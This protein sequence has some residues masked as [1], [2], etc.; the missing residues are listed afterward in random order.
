[1]SI[2]ENY[3]RNINPPSAQTFRDF[4]EAQTLDTVRLLYHALGY[5]DV[6]IEPT[7]QDDDEGH[8]ANVKYTVSEGARYP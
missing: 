1:M 3:E 2:G 4:R 5:P 7:I 8:W 6:A